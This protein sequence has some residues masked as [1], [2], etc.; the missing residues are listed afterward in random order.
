MKRIAILV[1]ALL[2]TT[3]PAYALP[4]FLGNADMER[5]KQNMAVRFDPFPAVGIGP[6]VV[7]G[8]PREYLNPLPSVLQVQPRL[9]PGTV[10]R[11]HGGLFFRRAA[12]G[13]KPDSQGA[14][15]AETANSIYA[16]LPLAKGVL[17][18]QK[19]NPAR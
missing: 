18:A 12:A 7:G 4:P 13:K 6:D 17:A 9:S 10:F 8:R 16:P 14:I 15:T 5:D 3:V 19:D 11:R 2:A 1:V